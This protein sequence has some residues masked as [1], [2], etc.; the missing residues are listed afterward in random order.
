MDS[1]TLERNAMKIIITL[2]I[3]MM[4]LSSTV[5]YAQITEPENQQNPVVIVVVGAAG[6]PEYAAQFTEWAGFWEKACI[7]GK[8]NYVSIGLDKTEGLSDRARL[9][10]ILT[11][12]SK[13]T[14]AALWLVLIMA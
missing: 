6:T 5:S 3:G 1:A 2:L 4:V 10:E 8:A 7:K 13:Q 9:Q 14:S 11:N 12:E